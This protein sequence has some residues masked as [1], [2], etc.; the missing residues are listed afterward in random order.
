MP[1]KMHKITLFPEK[2]CVHTI[3]KTFPTI[4]RST[5]IFLFGLSISNVIKVSSGEQEKASII[6]V[7]MG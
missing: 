2:I 4:I 6:R 5:H 7:G 1:F 3:P